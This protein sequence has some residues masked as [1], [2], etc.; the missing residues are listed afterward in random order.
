MLIG[1]SVS[2][3][4]EVDL[5]M[6]NG[7]TILKFSERVDKKLNIG[8]NNFIED[9]YSKKYALKKFEQSDIN[10]AIKMNNDIYNLI[11]DKKRVQ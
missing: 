3:L 6:R 1:Y 2:L 5:I 8:F 9:Y 7:E 4:K 10:A 11:K